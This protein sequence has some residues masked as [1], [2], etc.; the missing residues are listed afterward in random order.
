VT[1]TGNLQVT[2]TSLAGAT[3]GQTNHAQILSGIGGTKPY[4]W[5]IFSGILPKG[6][7]L[8]ASSGLISGN[9]SDFAQSETFAVQLSDSGHSMRPGSSR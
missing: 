9:V 1:S 4:N 8:N 2:T 7:F 6:L 5:S 3:A